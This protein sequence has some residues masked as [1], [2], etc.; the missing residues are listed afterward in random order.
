MSFLK[1]VVYNPKFLNTKSAILKLNPAILNFFSLFKRFNL[2]F[3]VFSQNN[4][5]CIEVSSSDCES[6]SFIG[7]FIFTN[8]LFT[9][10]SLNF[11]NDIK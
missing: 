9:R 5:S 11:L 8:S 7:M 3:I 2:C 4:S 6:P 1:R 10:Y